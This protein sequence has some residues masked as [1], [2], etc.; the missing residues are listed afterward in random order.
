[1]I[2]IPLKSVRYAAQRLNISEQ[3]VYQLVREGVL[4]DGVVVRLGRQVRIDPDQLEDFIRKG[5]RALAG[6]WKK[7]RNSVIKQ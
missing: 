4:P 6:G 3:R 1:M 7:E 2:A 5:G